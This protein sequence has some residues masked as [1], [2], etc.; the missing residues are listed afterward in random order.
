MSLNTIRDALFGNPPVSGHKPSREGVLAA[1]TE[2]ILRVDTLV[3]GISSYATVAALPVSPAEGTQARIFDDDVPVY[4]TYWIYRDGVWAIDTNLLN[5]IATIVQPL[6]DEAAASAD[7]ASTDASAAAASAASALQRYLDTLALYGSIEAVDAAVAASAAYAAA[8]LANLN[9]ALAIQALGDDAAAIA[10]RVPKNTDGS[11]F[12][13]PDVVRVTLGVP[14]FQKL[15]DIDSAV[16]PAAVKTIRTLDHSTLGIGDAPYIRVSFADITAAGYPAA[17]YRRSADRFMPNGSTDATNG[18]YWLNNAKILRPEM[19]GLFTDIVTTTA[20]LL[21]ANWFMMLT[22]RQMIYSQRY[23]INATITPDYDDIDGG[24]IHLITENSPEI[25][26]NA[27]SV[28]FDY[29]FYAE[30]TTAV[31]HSITGATPLTIRCNNKCHLGVFLRHTED[32]RGGS[33]IQDAPLRIYDLKGRTGSTLATAG[34]Y[35]IGRYDYIRSRNLYVENVDR[36][37]VGGECSGASFSD[38]EGD[39]DI[40]SPHLKN[41][42]T[43]PSAADADCLKTFGHNPGTSQNKRR[44]RVRIYDPVFENGQGR[45]YKDQCGDV[46]IYNATL[47]YDA[48]VLVGID[49]GVGFDFQT[50]GGRLDKYKII[51]KKDG[52]TSPVGISYTC[53]W[54]QQNVDNAS[55]QSE[56]LNGTLESDVEIPRFAALRVHPDARNSDTRI[57]GLRLVPTNG[58][59]GSMIDRAVLEFNAAEVAAC[60]YET[61]MEV[62]NVRGPMDCLQIGYVSYVSGDLRTKLSWRVNNCSTSLPD[63]TIRVFHSLSGVTIDRFKSFELG[64]NPGFNNF[65]G[66][67]KVDPRR[68]RAG[69]KMSIYLD[70]S[71]F[72]SWLAADSD[73]ALTVPWG[74]TGT[75]FLECKGVSNFSGGNTDTICEAR[76][77][78][79]TVSPSAWFTTDGGINWGP[80]N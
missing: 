34:F 20:T 24:E 29:V 39:V 54:F 21:A 33:V 36:V 2:I 30:S 1:F 77:N 45:C 69:S 50:G 3:V 6:I 22:K 8:A 61:H 41:I 76:L 70:T 13:Q 5:S 56:A 11:D 58:Y 28:A 64:D 40:Y 38:F 62:E 80:L 72:V 9:D 37:E 60:A 44:G 12:S 71:T 43:G 42:W 55:S 67:L 46:S 16:I 27:A 59:T 53:V 10:G 17:S 35:V 15:A 26:V 49:G 48:S 32:A 51:I 7:A 52:S 79:A 73:A 57:D 19:F 65:Y 63:V 47:I 18:G 66:G 25:I 4:N 74:T 75:L 78:N 68:L 31:N 14:T 23:E